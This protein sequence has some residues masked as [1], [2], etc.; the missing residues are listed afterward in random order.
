[1]R[2]IYSFLVLFL[3]GCSITTTLPPVTEYDVDVT[4]QQTKVKVAKHATLK[5]L[6]VVDKTKY[7]QKQMYYKVGSNSEYPYTQTR[8][9]PPPSKLIAL[10][11][12]QSLRQ[13]GVFSNVVVA[14]SRAKSDYLLEVSV[15]DFQQY[16]TKDETKSWVKLS[17]HYNLID[18]STSQVVASH[19]FYAQKDV[20]QLNAQGGVEALQELLNGVMQESG[21]WLERVSDDL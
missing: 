5:V 9:A 17:L 19:T 6:M 11:I 7:L 16:F 14:K 10:A 21:V 2:Y 3:A 13:K 15:E 18:L 1:M 4:P 12:V 20:T 8:W